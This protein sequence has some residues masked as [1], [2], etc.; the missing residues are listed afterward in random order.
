MDYLIKNIMMR[1][2]TYKLVQILSTSQKICDIGLNILYNR[3]IRFDGSTTDDML[4][5]I[6]TR[7]KFN[8]IDLSCNKYITN[9]IIQ[10]LINKEALFLDFN[11]QFSSQAL[12]QLNKCKCVS[13]VSTN[14]NDDVMKKLCKCKYVFLSENHDVTNECTKN[15]CSCHTVD[16]LDTN[17]TTQCVDNLNNCHQLEFGY[18]AV[19]KDIATHKLKNCYYLSFDD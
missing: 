12:Q 8:K 18:T 7:H 3:I 10:L 9:N 15:L 14:S 2:P 17:V 4:T 6:L 11:K 16:L 19:N 5:Y 13:I 1:L